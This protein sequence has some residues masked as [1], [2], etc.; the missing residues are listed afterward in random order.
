MDESLDQFA[1]RAK[2]KDDR[3]EYKNKMK[4]GK[5]YKQFMSSSV[6]DRK[7]YKD[8]MKYGKK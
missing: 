7:E 3:N 4:Y 6:D 8:K 5:D 1:R 2:Q